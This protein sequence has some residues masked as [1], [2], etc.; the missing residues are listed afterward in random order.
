[1]V[2]A[3]LSCVGIAAVAQT[4]VGTVKPDGTPNRAAWMAQGSFGCDDS[5]FDFSQG[6]IHTSSCAAELNHIVDS[7][8][9]NAF[10]LQFEV[11][12]ADWLIFT[13]GQGTGDLSNNNKTIDGLEPGL[14]PHR[15]LIAE[16]GQELHQR[17]KKLIVYFPGA[18]TAADPNVKRLLGL[19]TPGYAER[20][21]QFLRQYSLA[22]G[23]N[24]DGWWFDSCGPQ[25]EAACARR[26]MH[27]RPGM[28]PPLSPSAVP[29]S[30]LRAGYLS[31]GAPSKTIMR[32]KSTCLKMV[33]FALIY[34]ST[35]RW[36]FDR[37]QS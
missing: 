20:H 22:L 18:H 33:K 5:L 23:K 10:I 35:G 1:M 24:C 17:G 2:I 14:T 6:L 30:V 31:R 26:W 36:Y 27:V 13:L 4:P 3:T 11:T 34:L 37:R 28:Q 7:F 29:N 25:D 9:L 16:I 19:G 15:D 21:N 32:V 8:D 12:G